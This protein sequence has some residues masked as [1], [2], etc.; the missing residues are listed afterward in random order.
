M[1][2]FTCVILNAKCRCGK[3]INLL[4]VR[5]S[6]KGQGRD[7]RELCE[8]QCAEIIDTFFIHIHAIL[9]AYCRCCLAVKLANGT[10]VVKGHG[11]DVQKFY[12]GQ[13]AR[14]L[15]I[16]AVIYTFWRHSVSGANRSSFQT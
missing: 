12:Q 4:S 16:D 6:R 11:C 3:P 1:L 10:Y 13:N 14:G 15:L 2:Y 7:A 8:G 9:S 5:Y